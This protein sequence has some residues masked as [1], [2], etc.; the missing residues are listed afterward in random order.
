[1][2]L[3]P[4]QRAAAGLPPASPTPPSSDALNVLALVVV[5][6][7]ALAL[8]P[9]AVVQRGPGMARADATGPALRITQPADVATTANPADAFAPTTQAVEPETPHQPRRVRDDLRP[10]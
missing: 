4:T 8:I 2:S 9:L 3:P 6:A 7:V 5:S 1:M 10:R